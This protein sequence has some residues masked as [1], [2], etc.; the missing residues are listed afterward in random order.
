MIRGST[1]THTFNC[2]IA[3]DLIHKVRVLYS[4]NDVLALKKEDEDC[5]KDGQ[6]VIVKLTQEDT[7][8]FKEGKVEIQLRILTP[9][10]DSI[11]SNIHVV[12]VSKLL[13]DE[14]FT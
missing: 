4:Q 10:G 3:P 13:E 11:P 6:K 14:V 9:T 2:K 7:L 12:N 8:S 5:I 1:P